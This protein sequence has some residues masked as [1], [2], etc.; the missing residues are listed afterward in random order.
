MTLHTSRV[1]ILFIG[2]AVAGCATYRPTPLDQ[3]PF[4]ARAETLEEGGLRVT[5]S[6]LTREEAKQAFGVNLQKRGIQPIWL[7]I[8]NRNEK[9][10]WFMMTG[11]DPNYFSAH[12]AAYMNHYRFG[13]QQNKQMDAYFSDL[14]LDQRLM[15]GQTNSGFAFTNETL[16]TKQIRVKLYSSKDVRTFEFF[17]S[18]PGVVSDW[19]REGL[20]ELVKAE[21]LFVESEL[22]LRDAIEALPCCTQRADGT[23]EGDPI[24]IALIGGIPTLKAFIRSGWD[25]TA[26]QRDFSSLFGAAYLYGRPP[27]VQFQ[28]ARR[29]VSSVNLVRLWVSPIRYRGKVVLVGSIARS[30]DPNVDEAVQYVL[31]D[32]ATAESV[33]RYGVVGGVGAVSREA[34]RQNF[35]RAPYWTDGNRAV[36]E[37]TEDPVRLDRIDMFEWDWQRRIRVKPNP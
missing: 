12:E 26:F 17:I 13:G 31:E 3:I 11:L 34:P 22:E 5:V 23:G 14:G 8:E 16:G 4:Q 1:L 19:D 27:D 10:F 9:P 18:V 32:L 24:N 37:I 36:L 28:K 6:V 7:E 20:E 35:A 15:P 33:R 21:E 25:E 2:L 29:R 30:I